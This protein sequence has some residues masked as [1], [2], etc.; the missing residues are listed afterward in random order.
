MEGVL[1]IGVYG[2]RDP[3]ANLHAADVGFVDIGHHLHVGEV[4]GD[5]E[6]FGG[7]E[8]GGHRLSFLH[9]LR[10]DDAVDGR[11][12]G[13]VAQVGLCAPHILGGLVHL[14]L[15]LAV[16]ELG[17]LEIVSTHQP[18]IEEGL[19]AFVVGFLIVECALRA[20]EVGFGG[21]EFAGKVSFVELGYHLAFLY[22]AVV[23]Y[24]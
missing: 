18:F 6:E 20:R 23:I 14:L 13:G 21:V 16:R 7:V 5:G 8:T 11:G 24:V 3:L 10:Q 1:G 22:H 9:R 19:V 12:D 2:E 15:G 17:A 4:F